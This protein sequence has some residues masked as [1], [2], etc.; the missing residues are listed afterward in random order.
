MNVKRLEKTLNVALS[1]S[2]LSEVLSIVYYLEIK[3]H[4]KSCRYLVLVGDLL[5]I[6]I[7]FKI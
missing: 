5:F 7:E 4:F 2:E 3:A 6:L 1:Y